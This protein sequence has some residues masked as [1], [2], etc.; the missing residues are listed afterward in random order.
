MMKFSLHK[1]KLISTGVE[2]IHPLP[3]LLIKKAFIQPCLTSSLVSMRIR[4]QGAKQL[5]IHADP[6]GSGYWSGFKNHKKLN[7]SQKVD[8]FT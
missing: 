1:K 2:V 4:K 5:R 7:K 6:C 3:N 8:F